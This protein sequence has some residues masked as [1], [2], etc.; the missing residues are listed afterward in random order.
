MAFTPNNAIDKKLA[1]IYADKVTVNL[2]QRSTLDP[3]DFWKTMQ[4]IAVTNKAM[5]MQR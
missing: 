2:N 4:V 3:E 5:I 1:K